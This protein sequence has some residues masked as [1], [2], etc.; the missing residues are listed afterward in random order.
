MQALLGELD[1]ALDREIGIALGEA[2]GIEYG[3]LD[4][5]AFDLQPALQTVT[6]LLQKHNIP[7]A[8]WHSFF[9]TDRTVQLY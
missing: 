3:Y 7:W 6:G 5:L 2:E 1:A 8:C 4:I 9:T